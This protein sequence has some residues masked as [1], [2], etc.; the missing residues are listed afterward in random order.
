VATKTLH[1]AI[2]LTILIAEP[3]LS[4]R[5]GT[6]KSYT[7]EIAEYTHHRAAFLDFD[8]A[9]IT[10]K[11]DHLDAEDWIEFGLGR[12]VIVKDEF[13]DTVFNG[14][15]NTVE[16]VAGAL[17][18]KIGPLMGIGNRVSAVYAILDTTVNPPTVGDRTVT[19]IE[20]NEDSQLLYGIIEKI[21]SAG[22][23]TTVEANQLRDTFLEENRLPE[24]SQGINSMGAGPGI[25]IRLEILGYGH[26]LKAF[27]Y[28]QT[29][30]S[31]VTQ[32]SDKI[33]AVLTAEV[34]V[35]SII[36]TDYTKIAFNGVLVTAYEIDDP[37]GM[38]VIKELVAYGDVNYDRYMFMIDENKQAVYLKQPVDWDYQFSISDSE[39]R[40]LGGSLI[41]PWAIKPGKWIFI[42]DFLTGRP[43]KESL[44]TD[45]RMVFIESIDYTAPY[46]FRIQGSKS[47]TFKQILG[48]FGMKGLVS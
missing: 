22:Q 35:N 7:Q 5:A 32:I 19:T 21:V 40:T 15:A 47:N 37:Y 23:I 28:N 41:M 14:F 29:I 12:D 10:I 31:G 4:Q 39:L 9:S 24:T 45:P 11:S 16:I 6:A 3:L 18:I 36:S 26:W 30:A 48:Q 13:L 34:A 25:S 8:K 1:E 20:E 27:V 42:N 38:T 44:R 17:T 33:E 46:G 2:G 43:L